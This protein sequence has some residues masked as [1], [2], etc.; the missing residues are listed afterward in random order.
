MAISRTDANAI[1]D[2]IQALIF[3]A[4]SPPRT[5]AQHSEV[6][7]AWQTIE[8]LQPSSIEI[9]GRDSKEWVF[10]LRAA[11]WK[12]YGWIFHQSGALSSKDLQHLKD[13][14][15]TLRIIFT[16]DD[17]GAPGESMPSQDATPKVAEA[18][19]RKSRARRGRKP[20]TDPKADARIAEAW[21]TGQYRTF[22]DLERELKLPSRG[23][24]LAID[25]HRKRK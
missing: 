21:A 24:K 3:F 11:A 25:R 16:Y 10:Q 4:K 2:A 12:V 14:Q 23:A 22:A 19:A 6:S 9:P 8:R 13:C 17:A 1:R 7:S 20:D 5:K 15:D 18:A